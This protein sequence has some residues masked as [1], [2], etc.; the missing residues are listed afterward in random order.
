MVNEHFGGICSSLLPLD[1]TQLPTYLPAS[2]EAPTVTRSQVWRELLH[3]HVHNAPGSDSLPN[4]ILKVFAFELSEPLC[5][6]NA[7]SHA[8][9]VEMC[10]CCVYIQSNSN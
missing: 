9:T 4:R 8:I 10:C 5:D 1:L 3:I 7:G 6:I 2:S